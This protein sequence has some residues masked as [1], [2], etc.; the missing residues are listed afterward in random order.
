MVYGSK[1]LWFP[2][3]IVEGIPQ[4]HTKVFKIYKRIYPY[5]VHPR[6]TDRRF[7]FCINPICREYFGRRS[8]VHTVSWACGGLF[9][10]HRWYTTAYLKEVNICMTQWALGAFTVFQVIPWINF[11][12]IVVF[13]L[14]SFI[15]WRNSSS[16]LVSVLK[17]VFE[18]HIFCVV[19]SLQSFVDFS[20]FLFLF[21]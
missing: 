9:L 3:K 6:E 10:F 12:Y 2:P 19:I 5:Q 21:K 18:I 1:T 7:H 14:R 20:S 17:H 8:N 15:S 4:R 11:N 13:L 16:F